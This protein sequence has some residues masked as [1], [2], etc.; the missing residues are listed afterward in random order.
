MRE[1][2]KTIF[3]VP[4][5][6][7]MVACSFAEPVEMS[8]AAL[9]PEAVILNQEPLEEESTVPGDPAEEKKAGGPVYD[10]PTEPKFENPQDYERVGENM[11]EVEI[12]P[13]DGP[14]GTGMDTI[15]CKNCP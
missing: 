13:E 8:P 1:I 12:P 5:L 10:I 14:N 3:V 4:L 7:L 6:V 11:I 9:T 2:L 15:Y